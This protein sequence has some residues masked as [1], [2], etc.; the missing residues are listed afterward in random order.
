[1][2][3]SLY[4]K[5]TDDPPPPPRR[6]LPLILA[7]VVVGAAL[8]TVPVLSRSPAE[9]ADPAP[10]ATVAPSP[11][12]EPTPTPT[13]A[14]DFSQPVPHGVSVDMDYFS[15]ALFIGD[16]R[17]QGLR[18]YSGV[19]GA[20]FYDYTGLSIFGVNNPGLVTVDGQSWSIV[21]A[22]QK[23][24]QFKKIYIA[25]GMNELGYYNT[26]NYLAT[27]GKFLDQVKEA[28]PDA[29]VYLQNLAPVDEAKCAKYG[30]ASCIT[31]ARVAVFNELFAQL[32]REHRVCLV[33]VYSALSDENDGLP[34]EATSDGIHFQ[35][36]WYETW[37]AC[38]MSHTVDPEA[39]QAGQTAMEGDREI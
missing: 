15:D 24:P 20:T 2:S 31:N 12:P 26:E 9:G 19:K 29:V 1:M 3:R 18:L 34:S 39:Y 27:F 13:P 37:L 10:T 38:L 36:A 23:G 7:A 4:H 14:F 6:R 8:V 5:I 35:R 25:F 28:Q 17:T 16:S 32:A 33:D 21:E 30:Q 11:T 22:L